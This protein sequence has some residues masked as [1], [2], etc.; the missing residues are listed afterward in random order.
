MHTTKVY[1]EA[2]NY[3][4]QQ[5]GIAGWSLQI[6]NFSPFCTNDVIYRHSSCSLPNTGSTMNRVHKARVMSSL[7]D[8][9]FIISDTKW[10]NRRLNLRDSQGKLPPVT[11]HARGLRV[12]G[13]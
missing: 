2:H 1:G 4:R 9:S 12:R 8:E 11:A 5:C 6:I 13:V 10:F 3:M 7:A